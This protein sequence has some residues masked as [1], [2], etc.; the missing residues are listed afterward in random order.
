MPSQ[1]SATQADGPPHR[2]ASNYPSMADRREIERV[3]VGRRGS[4]KQD[5][6]VE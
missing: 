1:G 6:S 4:R 2:D 3:R 5:W